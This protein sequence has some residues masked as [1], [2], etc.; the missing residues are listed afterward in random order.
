[1]IGRPA[2]T[3]TLIGATRVEQLQENLEAAEVSLPED[4]VRLLDEASAPDPNELDH[5]FDN[6][7]QGMVNGGTNVAR[8]I[9]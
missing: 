2:V 6:V 3:S 1:V 5:F 7:L 8:T 4:T 9:F